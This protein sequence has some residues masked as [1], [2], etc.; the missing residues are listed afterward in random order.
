MALFNLL[1]FALMS[2]VGL[3]EGDGG[4]GDGGGD[5]GDGGN[6]SEPAGDPKPGGTGQGDKKPEK[7]GDG[8]VD[9]SITLTK[10][11]HEAL[12]KQIKEAR[13][14]SA[15]YRT[16]GIR[17]IAAA[18]G[19]ELP[20]GEDKDND[21]A[22]ATLQSKID[23]MERR[24]RE[25]RIEAVFARVANKVGVKPTLTFKYLKADDAF[26]ELDVEAADFEEKM[27][28]AVRAAADEEES[29][30]ATSGSG[31]PGQSGAEFTSSDGKTLQEQLA[32]ATE[33]GDVSEML[34]L[35]QLIFRQAGSAAQT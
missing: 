13:N 2:L 12:Q 25:S 23:G 10:A 16:N 6:K 19:V 35:K 15:K 9:D 20:E 22:L 26:K 31:I 21:K 32:A 24:Y 28:A 11:E 7:T 17:A 18:L 8:K 5:G 4:S 14:D 3:F 34:R 33:K 1:M 27:E 30:K 29:L